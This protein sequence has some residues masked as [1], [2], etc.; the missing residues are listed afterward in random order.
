MGFQ[1]EGISENWI[2]FKKDGRGVEYK[3]KELNTEQN[4]LNFSL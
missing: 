4:I 1:I 3:G 2:L